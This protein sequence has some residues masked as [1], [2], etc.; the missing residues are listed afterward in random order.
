MEV[1]PGSKCITR[2]SLFQNLGIF[3]DILNIIKRLEGNANF[4]QFEA[5]IQIIFLFGWGYFWFWE[6]FKKFLIALLKVK[7]DLE[8][9]NK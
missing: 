5:E 1:L 3:D 4:L 2:N 7:M 8:R 6:K 9:L